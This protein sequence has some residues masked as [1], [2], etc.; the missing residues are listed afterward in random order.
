MSR[1][2]LSRG[3]GDEEP[4][5]HDRGVRITDKAVAPLLQLQ[6]YAL[7]PCVFHAGENAIEAGSA[8]VEVVNARPVA[9]DESVRHPSLQLRDVL[10]LHGQLDRETWADRAV[11][12]LRRGGLTAARRRKCCD[13]G[14]AE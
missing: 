5:V 2:S 10:S 3:S 6:H 9:D 11:D 13:S 14:Y 4:A 1:P 8:Q 12:D 7:R